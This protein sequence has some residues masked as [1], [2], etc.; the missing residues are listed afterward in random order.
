[1][2]APDDVLTEKLRTLVRIPTVSHADPAANDTAAFDALLDALA[3]LFPLLHERLELTRV[4][5]HGLLAPAE[6]GT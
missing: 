4:E 3:R 1:M 5:E 6:S 2:T